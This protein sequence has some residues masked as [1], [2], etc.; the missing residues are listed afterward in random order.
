MVKILSEP[1]EISTYGERKFFRRIKD[2]FEN[3]DHLIVYTEPVVKGLHPDYLLL[4]PKYGIIIIEVKDY[5]PKKIKTIAKTGKWQYITKTGEIKDYTNPFDQLYHY[6]RAIKDAVNHSHFPKNIKI[7]IS[8][9]AVFSNI[10]V[11]SNLAKELQNKSPHYIFLCFKQHITRNKQFKTYMDSIIPKNFQISQNHFK[12]LRA[13]II[14][15][16]RLP[17]SEQKN[18]DKWFTAEERVKLLDQKQEKLA[19]EM[20]EGHRLIFGVA[21]SGKTIVLIARARHLAIQH[22]EW[23]IL[24]LCYNRLLKELLRHLLNPQDFQTDITIDTY[25]G[26]ARK[27]ILSH[28]NEFSRIY[29]EGENKAKNEGKFNEFFNEFVPNLLLKVLKQNEEKRV[30]Y[31]AI[32]IDEGQ[33]FESDWYRG[34]IKVLNPEIDSLLITCDGLQ[35]IYAQKNFRWSDVG[36]QARGRVQRFEKSYRTP[37]E[38]GAIAQKIIPP[39]LLDLLDK[40]DEFISTKE[41]IGNHGSVEILIAENRKQEYL[42]LANKLR[43][44]TKTPQEILILFKHNMEKRNY[45]QILFKLLEKLDIK[46]ND[47]RNYNY[48]TPEL[49]IGTLHGTKGLEFDTIIIPEVDTFNSDED[50]QLLYVGITRSKEKVIL[51]AS[52]TTPL[53]KRLVKERFPNKMDKNAEMLEI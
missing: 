6:W 39:N 40:H 35:G 7:P 27:Y 21:G 47:L 16:S 36:I 33:D 42:K 11:D 10:S 28:N 5:S 32:L 4:S 20:G 52:K 41:Y 37:I 49:L 30:N 14:P 9:I 31:D 46:W 22:P 51:T 45:E 12:T 1:S 50:R 48:E 19:R 29:H 25:H 2:V 24:I 53:L 38:I 23:R 26:W 15:S 8:R 44:L 43:R 3:T 18:L 17:T 34:I 13:N